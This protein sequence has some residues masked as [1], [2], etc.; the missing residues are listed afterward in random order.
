MNFERWAT[1]DQRKIWEILLKSARE[2]IRSAAPCPIL[3][4]DVDGN[5]IAAA[6]RNAEAAGVVADITFEV[7]DV[8]GL[9]RRGAGE[10]VLLRQRQRLREVGLAAVVTRPMASA[11]NPPIPARMWSVFMPQW[12][13]PLTPW[14]GGAPSVYRAI[15]HS[16]KCSTAVPPFRTGCTTA[17]SKHDCSCLSCNY[18]PE[19]NFHFD[20]P[21]VVDRSSTKRWKSFT[22]R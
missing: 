16:R 2:S 1:P 6:R 13:V 22:L 20:A 21:P 8:A 5:A 18:I 11:S 15:Q 17:R 14:P 12:R 3:A 19:T 4:R 9:G 10:V 7:A